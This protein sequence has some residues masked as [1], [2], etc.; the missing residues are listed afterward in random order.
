ME[1]HF[2][3]T[4]LKFLI[5]KGLRFQLVFGGEDTKRKAWGQKAQV[6]T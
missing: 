1:L 2:K 5:E 6:P 4:I 3:L